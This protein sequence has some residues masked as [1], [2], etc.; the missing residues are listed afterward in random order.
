MPRG[1]EENGAVHLILSGIL[2]LAGLGTLALLVGVINLQKYSPS[3]YQDIQ[4][5]K[6]GVAFGASFVIT[7]GL[8]IIL[9][10]IEQFDDNDSQASAFKFLIFVFIFLVFLLIGILA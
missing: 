3:I 9:G 6:F 7:L 5:F 2:T 4:T 8:F 10:G 1:H